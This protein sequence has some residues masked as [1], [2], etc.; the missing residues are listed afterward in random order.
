MVKNMIKT[1]IFEDAVKPVL[2]TYSINL[3]NQ[4]EILT[5][6]YIKTGLTFSIRHRDYDSYY[7]QVLSEHL[8]DLKYQ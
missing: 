5:V 4:A 3:L 6:T 1:V 8:K 2:I 7:Y